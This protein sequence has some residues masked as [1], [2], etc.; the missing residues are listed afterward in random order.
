MSYAFAGC[1]GIC[2]PK[3][4]AVRCVSGLRGFVWLG[5]LV[6][7]GRLYGGVWEWLVCWGVLVDVFLVDVGGRSGLFVTLQRTLRVRW[8]SVVPRLAR[9]SRE[10]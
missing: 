7:G 1:M 2:A 4:L 9:R 3:L 6:G 5:W 8:S 10:L